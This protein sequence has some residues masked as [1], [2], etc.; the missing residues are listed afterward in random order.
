MDFD[1]GPRF[2]ISETGRR[3]AREPSTQLE[4]PADQKAFFLKVRGTVYHC[5][6]I[7]ELPKT[8]PLMVYF[9]KTRE[10][11]E[12]DNAK[13]RVLIES[14]TAFYDMSLVSYFPLQ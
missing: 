3:L 2:M 9:W 10:I 12:M 11:L 5:T 1:K 13:R 6:R 7:A 14:K 4:K 8:E